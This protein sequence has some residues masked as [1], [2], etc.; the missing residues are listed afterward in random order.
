MIEH[1]WPDQEEARAW[2]AKLFEFEYCAEC[3][4]DAEHHAVGPDPFGHEYAWCLFPPDDD[5]GERHP[6]IAEFRRLVEVL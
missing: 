3:G 1:N 2:L 4:G 6:R 5:T